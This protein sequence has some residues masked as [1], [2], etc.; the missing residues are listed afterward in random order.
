MT[1]NDA[2]DIQDDDNDALRY[3]HFPRICNDD[4]SPINDDFLKV[5]DKPTLPLKQN[6]AKTAGRDCT[7]I[8][9]LGGSPSHSS[10]SK[11]EEFGEK[12]KVKC[13][14][15]QGKGK[16]TQSKLNFILT[17]AL[18]IINLFFL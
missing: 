2:N 13:P 4:I 3:K 10:E 17:Q 8:S 16:L 18:C 14:T 6:E 12:L 5:D 1:H 11:Y 9:P 15:C 7:S